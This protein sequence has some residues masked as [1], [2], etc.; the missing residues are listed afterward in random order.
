MYLK[1][2][3]G[4]YKVPSKLFVSGLWYQCVLLQNNKTELGTVPQQYHQNLTFF[5]ITNNNV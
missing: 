4:Y 2:I 3:I 1:L 5:R